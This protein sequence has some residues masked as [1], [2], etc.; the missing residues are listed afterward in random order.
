MVPHARAGGAGA[1]AA[2]APLLRR[3]CRRAAPWWPSCAP[4]RSCSAG[5]TPWRL[6]GPRC[7]PGMRC[8]PCAHLRRRRQRHLAPQPQ[9]AA[10]QLVAPAAVQQR[11]KQHQKAG[12]APARRERAMRALEAP[13]TRPAGHW[14]KCSPPAHASRRQGLLRPRWR[15][16]GRHAAAEVRRRLFA[17]VSA[18]ARVA[19]RRIT[20]VR[21]QRARAARTAAGEWDRGPHQVVLRCSRDGKSFAAGPGAT[22]VQPA[23]PACE[24]RSTFLGAAW[25]RAPRVTGRGRADATGWCLARARPRLLYRVLC[26]RLPAAARAPPAAAE[27]SA[28]APA[29][30][31]AVPRQMR[32]K[33]PVRRAL[34]RLHR[35]PTSPFRCS[36]TI[37]ESGHWR[38]YESN[39]AIRQ[40]ISCHVML[41]GPAAKEAVPRCRQQPAARQTAPRRPTCQAAAATA[42]AAAVAAAAEEVGRQTSRRRPRKAN[43]PS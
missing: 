19:P 35:A 41:T 38:E 10:A 39:R 2:L 17:G 23:D 33:E 1:T 6:R 3:C 36:T 24:P 21:R 11:L 25:P 18:P 8:P 28:L 32:P 27:W 12:K 37:R 34:R 4:R 43:P 14:R 30:A 5:G 22:S 40:Y 26:R 7:R 29:R 9:H 16:R 15:R 13:R 20:R 31:P 42:T